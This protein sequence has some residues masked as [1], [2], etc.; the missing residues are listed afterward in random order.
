MSQSFVDYA[1][2]LVRG[3]TGGDGCM[4]FRREKYEPNGGPD[5]GDGGHG[6]SVWLVVDDRL[7]TLMDVKIRAQYAA[8][9]GDKGQGGRKTGRSGCDQLIRVPRGTIVSLEDGTRLAD[10]T[11]KDQKF[12]AA[13]GGKG[14][15]GNQH[16]ATPTRQAPRKTTPGQSGEDRAILLELKLIAEVGLIGLPNAGKST[17]LSRLTHAKP[18][19]D[20]YPFTTLHPNLGVMS[21]EDSSQVTLADIPGLIE[22]ASR[23]QGLGDRFLRHIERTRLLVHLVAPPVGIVNPEREPENAVDEITYAYRLVR[24]ELESYSP[25]ML[26]KKE[27]TVLT[28]IDTL[29]DD[30]AA[31]FSRALRNIGLNPICISS[32]NGA[33]LDQLRNAI[34]DSRESGAMGGQETTAGELAE[35]NREPQA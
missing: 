32:E 35:M 34:L 26:R 18:G 27:I 9:R 12:L 13:A 10:L 5:G 31:L 30:E 25:A 20:V 8:E 33:G 2:I 14:G 24:N 21:C 19:I 6:G 23:G 3:G 4:S 22:G 28:K 16:F 17:L 11:V 1:R 29:T 7:S 15:Q